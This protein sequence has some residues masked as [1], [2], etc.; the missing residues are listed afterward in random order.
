MGRARHVR[1]S[2]EEWTETIGA[3]ERSGLSHAAFCARQ[4]LK[5]TTFRAWLYRLRAASESTTA[6]F[7]EV[8]AVPPRCGRCVIRIGAVEVDV[9]ERPDVDYVVELVTAIERARS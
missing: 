2:R 7:I 8:S 5:L 9:S 4:R 6:E 1:R 3:F